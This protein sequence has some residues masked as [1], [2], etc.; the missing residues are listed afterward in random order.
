MIRRAFTLIEL[1]V[2]VAVIGILSALSLPAL[3]RARHSAN[4]AVC[5][6]NLRQLGLG[7][8]L[9]WSDNDHNPFQYK[10]GSANNGDIYWFG[11]IERGA[12]GTRAF[13]VTQGILY[14]YVRDSVRTCPQLNYALADFKLKAT[15]AAYGYGYNFRLSPVPN[16]ASLKMNS[17]P[18]PADLAVFADA[19]QVNT[20]QAPASPDHPMLEEFYYISPDEQTT[21][22]RH[23]NSAL[24]VFCDGHVAAQKMD[25]GSLDDRLPAANV[26]RLPADLLIP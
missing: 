18:R 9:Y 3:Q 1:L 8:Q 14:P 20:F 22:F 13:D 23:N 17:V 16:Q 5:L 7:A 25:A 11:W 12:E 21:H 26:G 19:A 4:G 2:V 10:I 6:N 15:G 24:T